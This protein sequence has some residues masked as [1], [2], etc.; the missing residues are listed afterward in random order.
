MKVPRYVYVIFVLALLALYTN[1]F[2]IEPST[3]I[4]KF[5]GPVLND[6]WWAALNWIRNNT[7][8]CA[9][10][11]T[12]WDPGHFITGI[13]RRPVIFDGASQNS[14]ITVPT[15]SIESGIKIKS[16][17]NGVNRMFF[18]K[19][20]TITTA[21]I[22]DIAATL[23]T[24]NESLAVEILNNYR[25]PGCDEMYYIASA[26]LIGKSGWWIKFG[27]WE[28]I[29]KGASYSYLGV[30]LQRAQPLLSENAIVYVYPFSEREAFLI[31]ERNGT[32]TSFWQ[33]NN[34][35][36][37]IEKL[38]YVQK[39]GTGRIA[40]NDDAEV[41]GMLWV[42]PGKSAVIFMTPELEDSLFTRM[43]LFNGLGLEH[44]EPVGNWGGE[45]KLYRVRF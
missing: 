15:N 23:L 14:L 32:L 39:D 38:F 31:Y 19:N 4:S 17:D 20:G 27:T 6:N 3:Q 12:Y 10:I 22:Q 9:T 16:Y 29:S 45:V 25:K 40:V 35:L 26:D 36:L 44:F 7:A 42:D 2:Y 11:A 8:E 43:F 21:R 28:P 1:T 30:P 41:K 33:S 5:S 34:Q 13:A 18:Y 24:S 37:K